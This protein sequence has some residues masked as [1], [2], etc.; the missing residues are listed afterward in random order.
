ME[1]REVDSE[2]T[3]PGR[4][5]VT[6]ETAAMP[7]IVDV[8]EDGGAAFPPHGPRATGLDFD[9]E[10]VVA[11]L[12]D[13]KLVQHIADAKE[14][15]KK[16]IAEEQ[17]AL[18]GSVLAVGADVARRRLDGVIT[19]LLSHQQELKRYSAELYTVSHCAVRAAAGIPAFEMPVGD[20][21]ACLGVV[22]RTVD[23]ITAEI[24]TLVANHAAQT[25]AISQTNT[26]LIRILR[27]YGQHQQVLDSIIGGVYRGEA[28]PPPLPPTPCTGGSDRTPV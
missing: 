6:S 5:G 13:P 16:L 23:R 11:G 12:E 3:W 15:Y 22:Q 20:P 4:L 18:P 1:D 17:A 24:A 7:V 10:R 9:D 14:K 27:S 26:E 19:S 28:Q 21:V 25:R 2:F 8:H